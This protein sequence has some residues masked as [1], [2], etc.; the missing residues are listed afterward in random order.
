MSDVCVFVSVGGKLSSGRISVRTSSMISCSGQHRGLGEQN[1]VSAIS[2]QHGP[3][4]GE[5]RG[6]SWNQ[7]PERQRLLYE[8][9]GNEKLLQSTVQTRLWKKQELAL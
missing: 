5:H 8:T 6:S 7:S 3:V 1:F 4:L 2:S 9:G